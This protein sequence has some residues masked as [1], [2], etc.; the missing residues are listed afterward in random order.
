MTDRSGQ[1]AAQGRRVALLRGINVGG[2]RKVPMADLREL[3]TG[4]GW[5]EV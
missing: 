2:A 3:A 4:L 5:T 1:A